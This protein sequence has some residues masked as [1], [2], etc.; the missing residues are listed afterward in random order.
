MKL[1]V[2][3][4]DPEP[5]AAGV[6]SMQLQHAGF[7]TFV[8]SNGTACAGFAPPIRTHGSSSFL[9]RRCMAHAKWFANLASMPGW[10]SLFA[11]QIWRSA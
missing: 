3:V 8:A 1:P 11:C 6:L 4:F 9:I 10:I 2:L 5:V 7:A